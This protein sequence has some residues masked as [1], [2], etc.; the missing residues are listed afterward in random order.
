M[1]LQYTILAP[2]LDGK[3]NRAMIAPGTLSKAVGIDGRFT[4]GIRRFPGMLRLSFA[5]NQSGS[6]V[7]KYA[8][9]KYSGASWY[10]YSNF[11][12]FKYAAIQKDNT[13]AI[14]RGFVFVA[15]AADDSQYDLVFYYYDSA[16]S[17]WLLYEITSNVGA[18]AVVDIAEQGKFLYVARQ[19]A[20]PLVL[21]H[22]GTVMAQDTM[23]PGDFASGFAD[24]GGTTGLWADSNSATGG[25]L[26]DGTFLV[27]YRYY[28]AA[29][30][31]YSAL[32]PHHSIT[33][34]GTGAAQYFTVGVSAINASTNIEDFDTVEI[35]RTISVEVAGDKYDGG[36]LYKVGT[37]TITGSG[38]YAWT[39]NVGQTST[40]GLRDR[41]LALRPVIDPMAEEAIAPPQGGV[42]TAYQGT[43]FV[44]AGHGTG[45]ADYRS[46]IVWSPLHT[47][48]P[49]VFPSL[50]M[51]YFP[52]V[53]EEL[54]SFVQGSDLLWGLT[55]AGILR[56][57]K[58]GAQLIY[59]RVNDGRRPVSRNA[60]AATDDSIVFVTDAAVCLLNARGLT[61]VGA[62]DRTILDDWAGSLSNVSVCSDAKLGCT[63][64]LN[65]DEG[66]AACI[67]HNTNVVTTLGD[68]TF[69][70]CTSGADPTTGGTSES[71]F[72]TSS[73]QVLRVNGNRVISSTKLTMMGVSGTVNGTS[74]AVT[75]SGNT[76]DQSTAA[77]DTTRT[78]AGCKLYILSGTYEGNSYTIST[79]TGTRLT[80][81]G[82]F[83]ADIEEAVRYSVSPVPVRVRYWPLG[84][85][86]DIGYPRFFFRR[87]VI[88]SMA[89]TVRLIAG[90]TTSSDVN[91]KFQL[92][93]YRQYGTS[94]HE[95]K[96]EV[97]MDDDPTD[98]YA[99]VSVDGNLLE[100]GVTCLASHADFELT[101]VKIT[102]IL[103][104]S[105][106]AS[107]S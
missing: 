94:L 63:F 60:V 27:R 77:F 54:L 36:V 46:K 65:P 79:N 9:E 74:T 86:Q 44:G 12:F 68:M 2:S 85:P 41:S 13:S 26:S 70:F 72:L 34:S 37:A 106:A 56:F 52:S 58:V 64:I 28:S 7:T 18:I 99:A 43:T 3:R 69:S 55:N 93:M 84:L 107:T 100:P 91:A 50:N 73:G 11:K 71:W 4:G 21:Y 31:L 81:T 32:S 95:S 22:T 104:D 67:W 90:E 89:V 53:D 105:N 82:T 49:E 51:W 5:D 83:P 87:W 96:A 103:G 8:I 40:D 102:A 66:E 98:S 23:G 17:L 78:L 75:Q 88:R 14:L 24:A 19:G 33:L 97:A 92:G 15:Q 42:I 61:I 25:V 1:D 48:N 76:L 10:A 57:E 47:F 39:Y 20:A 6:T 16:T 80:I 45:A 101:A 35:Y 30:N 59:A 29:R 62:L 38:P